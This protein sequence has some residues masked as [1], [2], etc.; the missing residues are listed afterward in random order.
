[1]LTHT[2]NVGKIQMVLAALGGKFLFCISPPSSM[3]SSS[4]GVPVFCRYICAY[5]YI[6]IYILFFCWTLFFNTLG[7]GRHEMFFFTLLWA[8]VD[9]FKHVIRSD[10]Q[11]LRFRLQ[12]M[13]AA[14]VHAGFCTQKYS[15][16]PR[17]AL[18]KLPIPNV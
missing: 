1:M 2:P 9:Y 16:K 14:K 8:R 10:I 3:F 6:Y 7:S 13:R 17:R 4:L 5:I 11:V 15:R 18:Q 12:G